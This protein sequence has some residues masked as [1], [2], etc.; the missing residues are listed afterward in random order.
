MN[1]FDT[2][3][4]IYIQVM[5][6]IKKQIVSGKLQ[7]GDQ[8]ETVREMALH[9]GVNPNTIQRAL[10]ELEKEG[11]LKS[12]KT[13]GRFISAS[14][15]MIAETKDKLAHQKTIYYLKEMTAFGYS[16]TDSIK[17]IENIE[18]NEYGK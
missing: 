9:Y 2:N 4:P 18:E 10:Q 11:L 3:L 16:K 1:E 5:D 7:P 14:T 17:R 8:V 6:D 12:E 13:S 15:E